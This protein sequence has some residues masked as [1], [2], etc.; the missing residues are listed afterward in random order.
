MTRREQTK[1]SAHEDDQYGGK[2][3]ELYDGN[4]DVVQP[5]IKLASLKDQSHFYDDI[6][7]YDPIHDDNFKVCKGYPEELTNATDVF[8]TSVEQSGMSQNAAKSFRLLVIECKDVSRLKLCPNL[9]TNANS[10]VTKLHESAKP[11]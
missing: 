6:P 2:Q 3:N 4:Q 9:P 7:D 11:V 1:P 8:A 5:N 10:S